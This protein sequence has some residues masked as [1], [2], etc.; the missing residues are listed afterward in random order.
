MKTI[1]SIFQ[2]ALILFPWLAMVIPA[3]ILV[4]V[5]SDLREDLRSEEEAKLQA[6]EDAR[7]KN[8]ELMR[9]DAM[10][11]LE[12]TNSSIHDKSNKI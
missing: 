7:L 4:K 11:I 8:D 12:L 1:E 5:E 10:R 2:I 3:I 6:K 9:M